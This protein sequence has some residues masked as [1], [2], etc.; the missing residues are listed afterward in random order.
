M[1]SRVAAKGVEDEGRKARVAPRPVAAVGRPGPTPRCAVARGGR[2]GPTAGSG[3]RQA[4]CKRRVGR[5]GLIPLS[6][7]VSVSVLETHQ[8]LGINPR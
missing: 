7:S 5:G 8:T 1:G 4:A 2:K 3:V 6:V